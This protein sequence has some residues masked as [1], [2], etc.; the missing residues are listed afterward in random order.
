MKR[1]I[2]RT[3]FFVVLFG[4]GCTQPP[5][6]KG[7]DEIGAA[8]SSSGGAVQFRVETVASGL[9]VPW[10]IAFAPDGRIFFTER[11]GRVR[12]IEQGRLRP[13]PL[14]TISDLEAGGESGLMDLSLHPQFADNRLLYLAYAYRGATVSACASFAFAKAAGGLPSK[15]SSSRTFRQRVFTPG[16]AC[17]SAPTASSTSRRETLQ[18]ENWPNS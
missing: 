16:P 1:T 9:E 5:P 14:A 15:R 10:A 13:E 12:V 18:H 4:A 6:G 7:Q 2:C 8:K 11:P 3:L 17:G